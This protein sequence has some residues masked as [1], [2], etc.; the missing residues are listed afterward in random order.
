[1]TRSIAR[2]AACLLVVALSLYPLH[3]HGSIR[4]APVTLKFALYIWPGA[5]PLMAKIVAQFEKQYPSIHVQTTWLSG[6]TYWQKI[7]TE[8]VAGQPPD[9]FLD[10]GGYMQVMAA[11]GLLLPVDSLV[12]ADRIELK[13]FFPAAIAD[14]RWD[15]H[16]LPVGQGQLWG[17]PFDDQVMM[18]VY[19]VNM[20]KAAGIPVPNASW[21]WADVRRAAMK[22]TKKDASGKITQYGLA[23]PLSVTADVTPIV[24]A[25]GGSLFSRD[26]HKATLTAPGTVRAFR[27]IQDLMYKD[28]AA[29]IP[30]PNSQV[31]PF[32]S[33]KVAMT[34]QGVWMLTP[35]ATIKSFKW[36]IA[37]MPRGGP[38][39][40]NSNMSET[41]GFSI[42]K[43][44]QHRH[45][46]WTLV[47]WLCDGPG[48]Y[49]FARLNLE[50]PGLRAAASTYYDQ[51]LPQHRKILIEQLQHAHGWDNFYG[52]AQ[53]DDQL[54]KVVQ[55]LSL[56]QQPVASALSQG[57][58][59][60][61]SL[62]DQDWSQLASH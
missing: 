34:V 31:D 8:A 54:Q 56:S 4:K 19:N 50:P 25:F 2:I 59:Q 1:M 45:E 18:L 47:K 15:P 36:D 57:Q 51:P 17:L 23:L 58:P 10:D 37:Q 14:W 20:F 7:Q 61:Q 30:Q 53:I 52:M 21:T 62:L 28:R 5:Q 13:A 12:K 49:L 38:G 16:H 27:F 44:T 55:S 11:K 40:P 33:G 32:Q 3:A 39:K 48:Q 43:G 6:S 9:V 35:Y 60:V 24:W 26:F 22:L 41:D 46:A 42:F 29:L